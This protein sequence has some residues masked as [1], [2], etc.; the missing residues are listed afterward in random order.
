MAKNNFKY[1]SLERVLSKIYRDLGIEEISETD[2][3]EWSGEAMEFLG[4][5][6]LYESAVSLLEVKNYT[7]ELPNGL[8]AIVQIVR[9]NEYK[10]KNACEDKEEKK[11]ELENKLIKRHV[12]ETVCDEC[13]KKVIIENH[14]SVENLPLV[15][16]TPFYKERYTPIRLS[17][18]SFFNTL[19]CEEEATVYSSCE[20]EYT[21]VQ[22]SL[23]FSFKEG[24]V[25]LS[26]YRQKLDC[27]TGYPMIPDEVN[28]I[29]AITYYITWKYF[30]KMWYMGREGMSD[31]MMQAEERWLKYLTMAQNEF[32]VIQG[33]D[34]FQNFTEQKMN[35]LPRYDYYGYF[36][37]LGKTQKIS[38]KSLRNGTRN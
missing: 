15:F 5:L 20:D 2:V 9:D 17:N 35:L 16:S 37:K 24:F 29:S 10:M 6:S 23:R 7:A 27:E 14:W 8:H 25:L 3:I 19:V 36:G 1:I 22:D 32:K 11:K 12:I 13:N 28:V 34:Q 33:V 30:Q 26:Y 38:F 4:E 18:H 31:K 21:V